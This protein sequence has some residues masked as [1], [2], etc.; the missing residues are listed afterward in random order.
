MV[1]RINHAEHH[2][3]IGK[4][5]TYALC[6]FQTSND[7]IDYSMRRTV[8]DHVEKSLFRTLFRS[9]SFAG[10][11]IID[12]CLSD[13]PS[14]FFTSYKVWLLIL[15]YWVGSSSL[16][17][18][19]SVLKKVS[20]SFLF[21]MTIGTGQIPVLGASGRDCFLNVSQ[22]RTEHRPQQIVVG[23]GESHCLSYFPSS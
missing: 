10:G 17:I 12:F 3:F 13:P 20:S 15:F 18:I 6:K 21:T 7:A 9:S 8:G 14:F 11:D 2:L 22:L 23:T 5:P 4:L 19:Y 16:G 1:V